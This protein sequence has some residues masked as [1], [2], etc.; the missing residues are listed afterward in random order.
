MTLEGLPER[1][2]EIVQQFLA[3]SAIARLASAVDPSKLTLSQTLTTGG[4]LKLTLRNILQ[5]ISGTDG[6]A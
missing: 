3:A 1:C 6:I 5:Q 4:K 2:F